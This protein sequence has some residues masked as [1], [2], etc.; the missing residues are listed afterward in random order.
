M[1]NVKNV[2]DLTAS[3]V[4]LT[5][6]TNVLNVSPINSFT[7]ELALKNA[8]MECLEKEDTAKT[9]LIIVSNA[10]ELKLAIDVKMD[11]FFKMAT[12]YVNVMI[13]SLI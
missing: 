13:A 9:A 5:T 11:L 8:P 6:F 2:S 4:V 3:N 1:V 12:V 7:Q 10:T